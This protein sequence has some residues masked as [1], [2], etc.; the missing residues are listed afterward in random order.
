MRSAAEFTAIVHQGIYTDF[1]ASWF[2]DIG[3]TIVLSFLIIIVMPPIEVIIELALFYLKRAWDQ[4]K[5][6]CPSALPS[7]SRKKTVHDYKELYAGPV[8]DTEY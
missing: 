8:F 4:R 2:S 5:C 7:K 3:Y 1:S 6:C